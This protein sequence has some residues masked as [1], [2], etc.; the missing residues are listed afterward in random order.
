MKNQYFT[1][2][3]GNNKANLDIL[4]A[5]FPKDPTKSA[6]LSL[7][8]AVSEDETQAIIQG[9]FTDEDI[10][11]L[12][13]QPYFLDDVGEYKEKESQPETKVLDYMKTKPKWKKEGRDAEEKDKDKVDISQ[14]K[15]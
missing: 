15:G 5:K 12:K 11:W 2:L 10:V 1:V 7:H 8:Y 13:S 4:K 14:A 3:T 9:N 6:H